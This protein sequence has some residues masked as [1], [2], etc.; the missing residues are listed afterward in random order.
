VKFVLLNSYAQKEEE[1]RAEVL[2]RLVQLGTQLV[3]LLTLLDSG[4]RTME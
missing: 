2:T 3:S 1:E 4:T